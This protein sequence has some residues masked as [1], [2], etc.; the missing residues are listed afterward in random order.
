MSNALQIPTVLD[1]LI[2]AVTAAW[3]SSIT[4][5]E[6]SVPRTLQQLPFVTLNWTEVDISLNGLNSAFNQTNHMYQVEIIYFFA[7][8]PALGTNQ[9][10]ISRVKSTYASEL[11]AQIQTSSTFAGLNYPII[12]HVSARDIE[13]PFEGASTLRLVFVGQGQASYYSS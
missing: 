4:I 8:P 13:P 10:K 5:D 3:G 1:A 11:I 12:A 2:A 6:D 7:S 9:G